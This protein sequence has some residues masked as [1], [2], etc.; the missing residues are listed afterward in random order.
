M[1]IMSLPLLHNLSG[2]DNLI[3]VPDKRQ[4]YSGITFLLVVY[5]VYM[6]QVGIKR[7]EYYLF[8]LSFAAL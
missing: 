3:L 6:V 7:P 1:K 5:F 4:A 8:C 2:L